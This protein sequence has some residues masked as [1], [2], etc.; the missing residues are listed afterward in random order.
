MSVSELYQAAMATPRSMRR[1][2]S[3]LALSTLI[4]GSLAGYWIIIE[5]VLP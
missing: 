2:R 1:I 5:F 4:L 3:L